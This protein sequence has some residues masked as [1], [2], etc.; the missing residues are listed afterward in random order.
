[1]QPSYVLVCQAP[2]GRWA[3]Y[4]RRDADDSWHQVESCSTKAAAW[5]YIDEAGLAYDSALRDYEIA[6]TAEDD[7]SDPNWGDDAA[8]LS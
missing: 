8:I 7:G 2:S 3:V 4:L 5:S 1:M 6:A